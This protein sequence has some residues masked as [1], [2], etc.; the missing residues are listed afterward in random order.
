MKISHIKNL[1]IAGAVFMLAG[2]ALAGWQSD[3]E[4]ALRAA[5]ENDWVTAR[6][7][8]IASAGQRTGDSAEA[9]RLPG[10]VTEPRVWR[11][12]APFSP[13]FGAAYSAY[14]IGKRAA[15]AAEKQQFLMLSAAELNGLVEKGQASPDTLKVLGKVYDLLGDKDGAAAVK[16]MTGSFR[17]D[18]E[19]MEAADQAAPAPRANNSGGNSST[20]TSTNQGGATVTTNG[21]GGTIIK[22]KAGNH[23]DIA[24]L[25]GE[26]PVEVKQEKYAIVIGNNNSPEPGM[27][28]PFGASD[29]EAISGA[30][31]RY[32][33]YSPDQITTLSNATAG[34]ISA[35]MA[36]L[37]ESL[38]NS[39]T[40][41]IYF[42]GQT[43]HL[44]GRDYFAGNDIEFM[45]D[46]SKMVEKRSML[47]PLIAK[48][49]SVFLFVQ[50]H[51]TFS[52]NDYFGKERIVNGTISESFATIPGTQITGIFRDGKQVGVYTDAFIRTLQEFYT[53]TVPIT[54]FCWNVFYTMRGSRDSVSRRGGATQTPTL[55]ILT[56]LGPRSPF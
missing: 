48:G 11:D 52:G 19:F 21:N 36:T 50:T 13:N 33:G 34:E 40:V 20:S 14:R 41:L 49:A 45:T 39:A 27:E 7:A 17:V 54:D 4:R 38:P 22:V 2:T 35:A 1:L 9:T 5:K 56:N 16:A 53:N 29:A 47:Q 43:A 32:A 46:S 44:G 51:R 25:F 18:T 55:P 24:S 37:A 6:E 26:Q 8:F 15:D 30:L 12:G 3:Y 23:T 28:L 10:P 31:A 42:T